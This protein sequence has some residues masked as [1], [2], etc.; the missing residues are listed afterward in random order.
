MNNIKVVV[1]D[2]DNTLYR[3]LI[4][5]DWR[6]YCNNAIKEILSFLPTKEQVESIIQNQTDYSD[7]SIIKTLKKYG[8]S[9]DVWLKYRD[10]NLRNCD[11]SNAVTVANKTLE[12]FAKNYTLYIATFNT[13]KHV[14]CLSGKLGINLSYFKDIITV[15]YE[16]ENSDKSLMY[17]KIAALEKVK[18][19]EMFVIGDK[20]ETDI[21]PMLSIGGKGAVV[22]TVNFTLNDF[23]L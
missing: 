10:D 17:T 19:S 13:K 22:E 12:D 9:Y 23:N 7:I 5:D 8:V 16:N 18:P 15:D 20:F 2:F 6:P 11:V 1:F 14:E 4:I 21:A 3:N